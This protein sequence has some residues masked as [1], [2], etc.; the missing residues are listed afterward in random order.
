MLLLTLAA[1]LAGDCT[2]V[3]FKDVIDVPQPSILVLGERHAHQPD[4]ARA[5][6]VVRTLRAD[7]V[8]V[9]VALEAVHRDGQ[10]ILDRFD[11][12]ELIAGDLE[13]LL[14][15]DETWGYRFKPYAALVRA[16]AWG[17]KVVGVG[18]DLGPKPDDVEI[19]VPSRYMDILREAMR[20]HDMPLAM[21]Q[22]FVQ[23]MAWRDHEIARVAVEAWDGQG[24]LVILT[25]RGHVEGGKGVAWQAARMVERPVSAV[26]LAPG[27]NPPCHPGDRLWR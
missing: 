16:A 15:W 18:L 25:G 3:R 17:A 13:G 7:D 21:E 9:T 12:G 20:G 19:P 4:L 26:V 10:P 27:P 8:P 22:R 5:T 24:V 14:R 6:R 1:A 2:P 11:A 23:S